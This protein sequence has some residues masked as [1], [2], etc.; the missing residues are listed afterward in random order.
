LVRVRDG[1]C[2]RGQ[3]SC[4]GHARTA[5]LGAGGRSPGSARFDGTA[6]PKST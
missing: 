6:E 5:V 3:G 2:V 4:L 1:G